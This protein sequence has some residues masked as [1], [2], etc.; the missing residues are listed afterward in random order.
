MNLDEQLQKLC[1]EADRYGI[2]PVVMQQGIAPILKLFAEQLK[3]Q[4]YFILQNLE[5]NWIITTISN[6]QQLEQAK[7]VI[8]AFTTVKDAANFQGSADASIY[9]IPLPVTHI[10]FQILAIPELDSIV[11]LEIPGNINAGTEIRCDRIHEII[12]ERLQQLDEYIQSTTGNI[13]PDIA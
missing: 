7:K 11:F 13:P 4:E 1:D 12:Q 5:Q 10:L 6:T 3:H 9:A 8:Y 2:A